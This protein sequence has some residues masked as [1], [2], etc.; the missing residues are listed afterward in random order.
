MH[1]RSK[2]SEIKVGVIGYGGRFGMGRAHLNLMAEAGMTPAA[3]AELKPELLREA[4]KDFPGIETYDSVDAMLKESDIQLVT[5]ITPHNTHAEL[6]LKCLKAGRH[7]VMEK[8]F[9]ITTAECDRMIAEAR[10]RGR[11]LSVYHNRHW[12]GCIMQAVKTIQAGAIGDVYR[13][14]AHMGR[15]E[16]PANWWRS[17]RTLSG[18]IL[19][20][21]GVHLL[22]Y[23][24]QIIDSEMTEVAAFD[25][26]GYWAQ[27]VSWA[28]D[29][30][31]DEAHMVVRYADGRWSTLTITHLDS[32]PKPRQVE[33]TGTKGSYLFDNKTYTLIQQ[34]AGKVVRTDG[35]NPPNQYV[36]Y[37]RNIADHLTKKTELVITPEYARRPAHALDLA[38]RSIKAGKAMAVKYR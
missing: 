14:E 33:I 4:E 1:K 20:D 32:N 37:Y 3:V 24:F 30:N 5:V 17:R 27:K 7:V 15:W 12:D 23:T 6:G 10:K 2:A 34:K 18:G 9:A 25:T 36:R 13:V 21:W 11:V 35:A 28:G 8:P 26:S 38:R 29:T 22:E 16:Q 31:E 19:Y